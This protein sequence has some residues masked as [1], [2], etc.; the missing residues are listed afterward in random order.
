MKA[1]GEDSVSH[2]GTGGPS[3]TVVLMQPYFFPYVG[4]FDLLLKSDVFVVFDT[5]LFPKQSWVNRN[6]ILDPNKPDSF[7]Y[8]TVPLAGRA[9]TDPIKDVLVKE[10]E[11]LGERLRAAFSG[12][13]KSAPFFDDVMQLL[14]ETVADFTAGAPTL[15]RLNRIGLERGCERLGIP[16]NLLT[17]SELGL[18]LPPMTHPGQWGLEVADALGATDYLNAPG[19]VDLFRLQDWQE[20]R[21]GLH[22][23][24][25]ADLRYPVGRGF[26][27]Q[28][29][30]SI[31]DCMMWLPPSEI[32]AYLDGMPTET[33][34]V[35]NGQA[36]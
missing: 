23:T 22:L 12:Y 24:R 28:E 18:D 33:L 29:K 35:R 36:T 5:V 34:V 15:L 31:L 10:P 7:K 21:L 16:V 2:Q 3:S 25:V 9:M 20:R 14:D 4:Y 19:G 30:M 6:R 13:R 32:R 27:F 8:L 26:S 11:K 1:A 17:L